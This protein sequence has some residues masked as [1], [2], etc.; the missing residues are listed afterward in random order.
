MPK[1]PEDFRPFDPNQ[2]GEYSSTEFG[3]D[4]MGNR[5][6]LTGKEQLQA[7]RSSRARHVSQAEVAREMTRRRSSGR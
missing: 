1:H 6:A 3:R 2:P 7:I 4:P 5:R